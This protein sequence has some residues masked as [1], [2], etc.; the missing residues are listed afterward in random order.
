[1]EASYQRLRGAI[2]TLLEVERSNQRWRGAFRG[3]G[4]RSEVGGGNQRCSGGELS[5]VEGSVHRWKDW[6]AIGGGVEQSEVEWS[7]QRWTGAIKG[8][9]KLLEVKGSNQRWRDIP[10]GGGEQSE[11]EVSDQRWRGAIRDGSQ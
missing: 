7:D 3:G 2:R 10:K 9:S 8:G 5:K 1:M 6:E 11:V 4:K